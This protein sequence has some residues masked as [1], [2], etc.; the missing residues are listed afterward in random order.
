MIYVMESCEDRAWGGDTN[1]SPEEGGAGIWRVMVLELPLENGNGSK[2][3]W[4]KIINWDL[5]GVL[6]TPKLEFLFITPEGTRFCIK[7]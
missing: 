2:K 5:V 7:P 3:V 4:L 6:W 1:S